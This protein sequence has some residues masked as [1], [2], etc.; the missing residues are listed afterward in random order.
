MMLFVM[1]IVISLLSSTVSSLT[2]EF[3]DSM[4]SDYRM[5]STNRGADECELYEK[6]S[7][8][9]IFSLV[10]LHIFCCLLCLVFQIC[11]CMPYVAP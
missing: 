2:P 6:Q 9:L 4:M 5:L 11:V 3:Y 1:M 8:R 10:L 7:L